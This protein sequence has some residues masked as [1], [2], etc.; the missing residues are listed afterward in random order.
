M[1]TSSGLRDYYTPQVRG[2]YFRSERQLRFFKLYSQ[3][4][5]E[6]ECLS[7]FTRDECGCV[8]FY[9]PRKLNLVMKCFQ[10]RKAL[11]IIHQIWIQKNVLLGL[12]STKVCTFM[13]MDCYKKATQKF[14]H[15]LIVQRCLCLPDCT[16]IDYDVETSQS[17]FY[18]SRSIADVYNSGG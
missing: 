14:M 18:H 17:Q 12:Q 6:M 15:Q 9:M 7:N 2:C 11:K 13:K 3:K 4:K 5:C 8:Q 10:G 16:L 1:V